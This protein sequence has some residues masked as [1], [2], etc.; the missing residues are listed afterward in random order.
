MLAVLDYEELKGLLDPGTRD[1]ARGIL[2]LGYGMGYSLRPTS[3]VTT[4]SAVG[5]LI[6]G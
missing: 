5:L 3:I 6:P 2:F 4:H 1:C